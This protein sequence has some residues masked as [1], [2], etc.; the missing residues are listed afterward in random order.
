MTPLQ[1][2]EYTDLYWLFEVPPEGE[3]REAIYMATQRFVHRHP[4]MVPYLIVSPALREELGF[5]ANEARGLER[6]QFAF[7]LGI[8]R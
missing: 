1:N 3:A 6:R 2:I 5:G 4:N 8:R 7:V